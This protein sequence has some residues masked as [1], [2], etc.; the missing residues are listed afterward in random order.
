[1]DVVFLIYGTDKHIH[2]KFSMLINMIISSKADHIG[3][4]LIQV[5]GIT[6]YLES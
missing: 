5:L 2:L 6:E 1:M 3:S 4:I